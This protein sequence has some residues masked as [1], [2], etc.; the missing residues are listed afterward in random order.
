MHEL[1][2]KQDDQFFT[3]R[4]TIHLKIRLANANTSKLDM[5]TAQILNLCISQVF[6]GEFYAAQHAGLDFKI[7]FTESELKIKVTGFNDKLVHLLTNVLHKIQTFTVEQNV[8][9]ISMAK[10]KQNFENIKFEQPVYQLVREK[11]DQ[12]NKIPFVPT[13][14][15]EQLLD[16][17]TIDDVQKHIE[18]VFSAAY[19]KMLM[20]GN[21]EQTEAVDAAQQVSQMLKSQPLPDHSHV[22]SQIVNIEPGHYIYRHMGEDLNMLN[23]AV[24]ATF[25][26]G[27]VTNPKDRTTMALLL[28]IINDQFFN[29]IRTK[30]QLG[31]NSLQNARLDV[32]NESAPG[33]S[34]IK[35]AL[36]M[37]M[38][39]RASHVL[40]DSATNF[41]H[42]GMYQTVEGKWVITDVDKFKATQ[43]LHKL[44]VPAIKLIPNA[45]AV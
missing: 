26:C 41:A 11:N 29:Q 7:D 21:F 16:Q 45:T 30:E 23:N 18:T 19:F 15:L 43:V 3:P 28:Q 36:D 39:P 27:M 12:L 17:V 6:D 44:P 4:G 40:S 8:Y 9:D 14:S 13:S 20:V 25:Y 35:N 34:K 42:I 24:V 33:W 31:F 2:F 37:A 1:W 10:I 22:P 5:L 38:Y 32:L